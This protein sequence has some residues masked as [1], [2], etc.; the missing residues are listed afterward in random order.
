MLRRGNTIIDQLTAY[1]ARFVDWMYPTDLDH[2]GTN[3]ATPSS[4]RGELP[5]WCVSGLPS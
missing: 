3:Y 4:L 5:K 2:F 1:R